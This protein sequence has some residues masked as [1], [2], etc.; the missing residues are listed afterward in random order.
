MGAGASTAD[1]TSAKSVGKWSKEDVG[2]QVASIGKAFEPYRDM[3]IENDV[4]GETLL[5]IDEAELAEYGVDKAGHRK[6]IL[7]KVEDLKQA[8]ALLDGG[9]RCR[10]DFPLEFAGYSVWMDEEGIQSGANFMHA[11]GE[12]I[13]HSDALVAVIDQKFCR[14]T[15]CNNE[16]A[17]AQGSGCR[18]LP[19]IFRDMSFDAMPHGLKYML[20][21]I[22]CV[23]FPDP[24]TDEEVCASLLDGAHAVL[25]STGRRPSMRHEVP[26]TPSAEV[27]LAP[28]AGAGEKLAPV[29]STVPEPPDVVCERE[30]VLLLTISNLLGFMGTG[31]VSLSSVKKKSKLSS[32]GQGGAGK[33]TLAAMLVRS[34]MVQRAFERIAWVSV[35]QTPVIMELQQMMYAQLTGEPMEAKPGTTADLQLQT[36]KEACVGN[37]W[38]VV[39]DDVWD[40]KHERLLNCIDENTASKLFVTTRIRGLLKGCDEIS[41]ELLSSEEAIDLLLRTGG[42]ESED[43]TARKAAEQVTDLCGNLPL[44]IGICGGIIRNY[45]GSPEWQADL[46]EMLREDRLEVMGADDDYSDETVTRV[47]GTSLVMLKDDLTESALRVLS[48]CPE[49]VP[50]PMDAVQL[51]WT[52]CLP[53]YAAKAK[54]VTVRKVCTR[55]LDRNLLMGSTADGVHLHDIVR[56]YMRRKF[57]GKEISALQRHVVRCII[58]ATPGDEWQSDTSLARYVRRS[59]RQHMVEAAPKSDV[60]YDSVVAPWMD[61]SEFVQSSFVVKTAANVVGIEALEAA[62][63]LH[64]SRAEH[65]K[66]ALRLVSAAHTDAFHYVGLMS[67]DRDVRSKHA[68]LLLRASALLDQ[69][70]EISDTV[71]KLHLSFIGKLLMDFMTDQK[72]CAKSCFY[73]DYE[74]ITGNIAWYTHAYLTATLDGYEIDTVNPKQIELMGCDLMLMIA[75]DVPGLLRFGDIPLA[76]RFQCI[77]IVA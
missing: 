73:A 10:Q 64:E 18:L 57:A 49:D 44:L 29:P 7:K 30:D 37:H 74:H 47:I 67:G 9:K 6:K 1:M 22:N 39:L 70:H 65:V 23:T 20:A 14:S 21:S 56:D 13:H 25:A 54:S 58:D 46:I 5:D 61:T 40:S 28:H 48:L 3:A 72:V 31:A 15:Y 68:D 60:E 53:E 50:I 8:T 36:L 71:R 16:L 12:A 38:L 66:A 41:L 55:L 62:S 17:L 69:A 51:I 42:V 59:L 77:V 75:P 33:T 35:G 4:D 27:Q 26:A 32:H 52:A 11:I 19:C 45:D 24:S 34:D 2:E 43:E 63:A 76:L